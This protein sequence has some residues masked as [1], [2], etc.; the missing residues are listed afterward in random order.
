MNSP[1]E[2]VALKAAGNMTLAKDATDPDKIIVSVR[3]YAETNG[4]KQ[5]PVTVTRSL[6]ELI[7]AREWTVGELARIDVMI[8]DFTAAK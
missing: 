5:A 2:Y 8:A 1:T 6:K 3:K 7:E 4:V